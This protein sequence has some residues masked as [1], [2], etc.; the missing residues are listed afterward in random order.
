[1]SVLSTVRTGRHPRPPKVVIYGGP[2]VGKSSFAAGIPD[3]IF[4]QTEE[5]LDALDVNSFPLASSY[6]DVIKQLRAL[7][8]EKHEYK[9]VVIDSLDWL[10]PL[11][12]QTVVRD[13]G[14]A[15][16]EAVG[17]GYGKGYAEAVGYWTELLRA[18]DHLRDN[19]KM[20]IVLIAHDEIRR[21]EPV[22]SEGY[23]YA[24]LK[25]HKRAA[26]KVEEWADIIGYARTKTLIRSDD[27]GFGKRHKRAISPSDERELV[28]GQNPAYVSGN[29]YGMSDILPLDWAA[30]IADLRESFAADRTTPEETK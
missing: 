18:L 22:D 15:T 13:N 26:A 10:E 4:V 19:H 14:V 25:L 2:K 20:T 21:M 30:F 16:I 7:A 23:D 6:M 17:G 12:W 24:A 1:M 3:A 5:G 27:T 9:A 8:T 29:R 11:I 28:V